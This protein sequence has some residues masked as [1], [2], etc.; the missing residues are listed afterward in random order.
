MLKQVVPLGFK[1][2]TK[3]LVAEYLTT[4]GEMLYCHYNQQNSWVWRPV[5]FFL[6]GLWGYSHCGHSWSIVPASGDSEEDCGEA[7]GM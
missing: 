2:V 6:F 3:L 4:S 5:F 1:E 7:D